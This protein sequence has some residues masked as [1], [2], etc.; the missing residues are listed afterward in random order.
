MVSAAFVQGHLKA[1]IL[2]GVRV[3][4]FL[5]LVGTTHP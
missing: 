3:A 4:A 1:T 2:R 5:L